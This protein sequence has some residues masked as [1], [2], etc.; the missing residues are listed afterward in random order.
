MTEKADVNQP[1]EQD[2]PD[3]RHK[4][5]EDAKAGVFRLVAKRAHADPHAWTTTDYGEYQQRS[6]PDA[7][8]SPAARPEF[9]DAHEQDRQN[10]HTQQVEEK[11]LREHRTSSS[12]TCVCI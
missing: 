8:T 5:R 6:F 2:H 4:W 1:Q 11:R 7:P 10:I 9:V 3:A 12:R